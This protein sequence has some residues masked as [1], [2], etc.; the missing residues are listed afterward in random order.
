M[1]A[2]ID[3]RGVLSST[4]FDDYALLPI[5]VTDE[6]GLVSSAE[7]DYRALH[8]TLVTDLNGN[9]TR[10]RFTP[11]G[12]LRSVAVMGKEGTN[13]GDTAAPGIELTYG[14]NAYDVSGDPLWVR[15]ERHPR[16]R[17]TPPAAGDDPPEVVVEYSDGFGRLLQQRTAT[18]PVRIG[19]STFGDNGLAPDVT[20]ANAPIV[21]VVERDGCGRGGF[22]RWR[23]GFRRQR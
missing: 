16:H 17:N 11:L 15:T 6:A 7:I 20:A 3:A 22:R 4:R 10:V 1:D 23:N 13:E 8:P 5:E 14:L 18:D 21:E 19:A 9:R 2:R 12:L